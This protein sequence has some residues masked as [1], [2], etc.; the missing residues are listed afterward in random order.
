MTPPADSAQQVAPPQEPEIERIALE[1]GGSHTRADWE[2][3]AAGVL[4]KARRLGDD[5]PDDRVEALLTRTTLDGI[6][7]APLGTSASIADVQTAGRPARVGEWDVRALFVDPD[8]TAT[9]ADIATDLDNGVT[10]VWLQVGTGGVPV[11]DLGAALAGVLLDVAPVVLQASDPV[12]A[13]EAFASA[14]G[15]TPLADGTNLGGDPLGALARES[16]GA[17]GDLTATV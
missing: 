16:S 13:A 17:T 1:S 6:A 3:L 4:R 7:V 2:K 9:A 8:A 14:A 5:D 10:S 15:G 12:A 11:A